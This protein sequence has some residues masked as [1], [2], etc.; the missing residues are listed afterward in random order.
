[1][2][3]SDKKKDA[4]PEQLDVNHDTFLGTH[5]SQVVSVTVSDLD[6]T[7]EFVYVNP[8]T[9]KGIVVSRVTMAAQA[10]EEFAKLI[11]DTAG[12]HR[13][14]IKKGETK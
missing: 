7:F 10:A 9:K 6:T 12:Q 3:D 1:M 5:Y 13:E 14:K 11:L 8:Q 2:E 4:K